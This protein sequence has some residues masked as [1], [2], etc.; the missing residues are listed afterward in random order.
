MRIK[1][2]VDK[3]WK[4]ETAKCIFITRLSLWRLN[5]FFISARHLFISLNSGFCS[6]HIFSLIKSV[7][8]TSHWSCTISLL[9]AR[10][11]KTTK[12]KWVFEYA[13]YERVCEPTPL[14]IHSL[15]LEG[16]AADA[17]PCVSSLWQTSI[18]ECLT[19]LDNGVVFVGSRLGDSQL[20]KVSEKQ[21]FDCCGLCFYIK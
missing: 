4:G 11:F 8:L 1:R 19:Y 21:R 9:F 20:V 14:K 13:H 15:L 17:W 6:T 5:M 7:T 16:R 10:S 18:A 2:V 3:R 12:P